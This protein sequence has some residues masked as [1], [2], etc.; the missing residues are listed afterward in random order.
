MKKED[1]K[2]DLN[3]AYVG[4]QKKK[5]QKIMDEKDEKERL[6]KMYRE[7]NENL[8]RIDKEIEERDRIKKNEFKQKVHDLKHGKMLDKK[9]EQRAIEEEQRKQVEEAK[10]MD[11]ILEQKR[12]LI[13]EAIKNLG[14]DENDLPKGTGLN[15]LE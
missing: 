12:Q 2:I 14:L 9:K 1:V 4:F 10:F 7:I 6:N 11:K 3:N 15:N 8:Q 5:E 13:L